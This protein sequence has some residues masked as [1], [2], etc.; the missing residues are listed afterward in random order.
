MQRSVRGQTQEDQL[1][2]EHLRTIEEEINRI[3][4]I[5]RELLDF[6]RPDPVGQMVEVNAVIQSLEILLAQN[7]REQQVTLRVLLD[8]EIPQVRISGDHLKQV[9]LNLVRNA[10]DAMP[11]GGLL[12]I[13]T[14]QVSEGITISVTDTGCGIAAEH[15]P[16]LFDPFFTTK[17]DQGG[18]G[19]G[20]SVLYGIITNAGG[21]IEVESGIGKGS[22]FRVT[23]PTYKV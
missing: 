4:R 8:P 22:T 13:H 1:T 7:L 5:L 21:R 2:N 20:L 11:N 18:M 17:A 16:Y 6:S 14:G 3:A 12:T 9:L 10:E 23:L 19:L 15:V